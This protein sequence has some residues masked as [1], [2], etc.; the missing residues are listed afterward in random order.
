MK[1]KKFHINI[2]IIISFFFMVFAIIYTI[3]GFYWRIKC[4]QTMEL[5]GLAIINRDLEM[6][7]QLFDVDCLLI[8]ENGSEIKYNYQRSVIEDFLE[9]T[10]FTVVSYNYEILNWGSLSQSAQYNLEFIIDDANGHESILSASLMLDRKSC[11]DCKICYIKY[12][13]YDGI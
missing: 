2:E 11:F 6:I 7:D 4:N 12:F 9:K 8:S 5:L 10:S 13:N 3:N 1:L